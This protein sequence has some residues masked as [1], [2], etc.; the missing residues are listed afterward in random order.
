MPLPVF[1]PEDQRQIGIALRPAVYIMLV[2]YVL[3]GGVRGYI[4]GEGGGCQ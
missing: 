3:M 2:F 1:D 4:R